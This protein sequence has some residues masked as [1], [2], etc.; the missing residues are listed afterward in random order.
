MSRLD[1]A[2]LKTFPLLAAPGEGNPPE[3]QAYGTRFLAANDGVWREINLPWIRIRHRLAP[4]LL[5]MPY[6]SVGGALELRCGPLPVEM[7]QAFNREARAAAP[8]EI[9]GAF[10]WD[11]ESG[12]WRYGRRVALQQTH[13]YIQYEEVALGEDESLVVDVHSHGHH[14]AFFSREDDADDH[15]SM[16]FS[17]VVGNFDQ[18]APTSRMRLCMAGLVMPARIT[19]EGELEVCE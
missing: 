11:R 12:Q 19:E 9:A 6:G 1:E 4:S 13:S 2:I 16:K 5:P 8:L 10:L 18:D 14:R 17:L 3:A 7:V 15:G